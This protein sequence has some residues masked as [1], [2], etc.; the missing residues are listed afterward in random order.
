[1]LTIF[2]FPLRMW[3]STVQ[4]NVILAKSH[5]CLYCSCH[6]GH[7]SSKRNGCEGGKQDVTKLPFLLSLPVWRVAGSVDKSAVNSF[8]PSADKSVMSSPCGDIRG[9]DEDRLRSGGGVGGQSNTAKS[10]SVPPSNLITT[11]GKRIKAHIVIC[12]EAYWRIRRMMMCMFVSN[13]LHMNFKVLEY[14]PIDLSSKNVRKCNAWN[15]VFADFSAFYNFHRTSEYFIMVH[16]IGN[17]L[18]TLTNLANIKSKTFREN[19]RA[20]LRWP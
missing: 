16:M 15:E 17:W 18:G 7:F 13:S 8:F 4:P 19:F 9:L 14:F 12:D 5:Y 20:R 2:S 1:M 11:N 10:P 3:N 6:H